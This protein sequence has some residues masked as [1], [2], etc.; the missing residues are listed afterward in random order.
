MKENT[1]KD[2]P[3]NRREVLKTLTLITGY[4]LTAGSTA[5]FLAGCKAEPSIGN[6]ASNSILTNDQLSLL[7]EACERIIPKT[8]TPG[9]KD[10]H[11]AEY[12]ANAL[13]NVF[14]PEQSKRFIDALSGFDHISH[15]RYKNKFVSISDESKDEVLKVLAQEWKDNKDKEGSYSV[16]KELRDLTVTGF[17]A[18]EVGAKQF[19][20]YDPV[21]GPY[22]GCIDYSKVGGTYAL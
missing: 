10:A 11:V 13:K 22:Q 1:P 8:N 5:A 3:L 19:F 2:L 7:A 18:S 4:T 14:E 15:N 16:F 12:I 20:I 17:A 21:P 6:L 9:A